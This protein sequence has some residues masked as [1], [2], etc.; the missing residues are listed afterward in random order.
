MA[1]TVEQ[2][3]KD[4]NE[5]IIRTVEHSKS[6]PETNYTYFTYK[7]YKSLPQQP[8]FIELSNLYKTCGTLKN[9]DILYSRLI[10]WWK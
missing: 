4:L 5:W 2:N 7:T 10:L 9:A 3:I 8:V 1:K 6:S